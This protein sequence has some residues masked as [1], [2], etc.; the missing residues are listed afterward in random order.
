MT[1]SDQMKHERAILVERQRE[2]IN[3]AEQ[4]K[5]ESLSEAEEAEY[6]KN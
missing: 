1:K 3:Q 2:L 4:Q 5:R 6:G